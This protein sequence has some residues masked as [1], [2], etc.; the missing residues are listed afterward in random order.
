MNIWTDG[1]TNRWMDGWTNIC[2]DGWMNISPMKK[3]ENVPNQ[4]H[5]NG[6]VRYMMMGM[7]GNHANLSM[8]GLV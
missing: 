6:L 5:T 2:M 7:A 8:P 3:P 1:W 4:G